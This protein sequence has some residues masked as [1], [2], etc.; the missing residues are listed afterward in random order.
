MYLGR[1]DLFWGRWT[2]D[3]H[4]EWTRAVLENFPDVSRGDVERTRALM[5]EAALDALVT[6][7]QEV[8]E[9]LV[10][11]DPNDRHVLAAA[12]VGQADA[13][14]TFNVDDFPEDQVQQYDIEVIHPDDFLLYQL[15]LS[16]SQFLGAVRQ[17]RSGLK[18]PPRSPTEYLDELELN[19]VPRTVALLRWHLEEI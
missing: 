15:D 13:I 1:T 14:V 11:P 2:D 5:D 6:G 19:Q 4:E 9:H 3:I 17:H 8:A 18:N 16:S 7:Y 12:I 10:L